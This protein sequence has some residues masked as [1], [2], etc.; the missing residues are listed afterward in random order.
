MARYEVG[1]TTAA[2][3][4]GA[5]YTILGAGATYPLRLLEV[6]IF[7]STVTAANASLVQASALGTPTAP[8]N[9]V[10][11]MSGDAT[12]TGTVAT[13]WSAAA[14]LS[15]T[16]N[17]RGF[18]PAAVGGGYIWTWQW[19][20]LFVPVSKGIAVANQ[21]GTGQILSVYFVWDE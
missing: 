15:A 21:T 8:V 10:D 19:P 14:T 7:N 5:A 4:A 17:R 9:G 13:A 3:A 16:Y 6:G 2:A 11:Q 20:G 12:S 18:L 1:V